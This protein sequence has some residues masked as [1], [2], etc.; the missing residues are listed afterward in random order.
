MDKNKSD[1]RITSFLYGRFLHAVSDYN[2]LCGV[3]SV[4]VGFS[5][6]ADSTA[7]LD[8]LIRY[9]RENGVSVYALHVNHMIRGA[10]AERDMQ[11]CIDFCTERGVKLFCISEN[12]PE[13]AARLG[14]GMEEAAR[15]VRYEAFDKICAENRIERIATAHNSS[16]NLETVLFNLVRGSGISGLCGIPPVRDNV[17]RP[18]IYCSKANIVSYCAENGLPY[19]TDG[20]NSDIE[21]TRNYIRHEIIPHL[22]R[23]NASVEDTVAKNC[24]LLRYDRE[25]LDFEAGRIIESISD[26]DSIKTDIRSLLSG[27]DNSSLS[28]TLRYMANKSGCFADSEQIVKMIG[29]IRSDEPYGRISVS[30]GFDFEIDREHVRFIRHR[31]THDGVCFDVE[32]KEGMNY[33]P[34]G[35]A[36]YLCSM[37]N[38][39]KAAKDIK[40]FKN[41]YK[42]SIHTELNSDKIIGR[43]F[44]RE[45]REGDL[46]RFGNMTRNVRKLMQSTKI[47]IAERRYM[48]LICDDGGICFLP[49]FPVRDG[50]APEKDAADKIS[51]TYFK[52]EI[53]DCEKS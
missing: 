36:L 20:T 12:V 2:M 37:K 30:G 51:I 38:S 16:D 27:C 34:G 21:Y 35:G 17:I 26:R 19:V 52:G 6:G 11:F 28:R 32:L 1:N 41:I 53:Y 23:L 9:G 42:L 25:K 4:L 33:L 44:A 29:L 47:S 50:M 18:L 40:H 49:G 45:R 8:M 22:K 13:I 14:I 3:R 5:G 7:L 43:I 39:E 48:P 10:E 15:K 46:Y 24:A 31:E